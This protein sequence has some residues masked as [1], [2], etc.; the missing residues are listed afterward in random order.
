MAAEWRPPAGVNGSESLPVHP[1]SNCRLV[2]DNNIARDP[3]GGLRRQVFPVDAI[4]LLVD[5]ILLDH[6]EFIQF[7]PVL[8]FFHSAL[9]RVTRFALFCSY[10]A[11]RLYSLASI[12]Q[13]IWSAGEMTTDIL[14]PETSPSLS[15]EQS[16]PCIVSGPLPDKVLAHFM[17]RRPPTPRAFSPNSVCSNSTTEPAIVTPL[18]VPTAMD[19]FP[20]TPEQ[21][22]VTES[23]PEDVVMDEAG[24]TILDSDKYNSWCEFCA[25]CVS[26][27][28]NPRK[29]I[30]HF[31]GRN[32]T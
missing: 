14:S 31:F 29:C 9:V 11:V 17:V 2:A 20:L 23:I 27:C 18:S 1:K 19:R 8:S 13:K 24:N 5:F 16:S 15:P 10:S 21:S 22:P 25:E 26:G 28:P 32:K 4:D 3:S 12:T 30:S 7:T 6:L